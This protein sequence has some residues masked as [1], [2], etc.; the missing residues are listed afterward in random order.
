MTLLIIILFCVC[1]S[2]KRSA[3]LSQFVIHRGLIISVMQVGQWSQSNWPGRKRPISINVNRIV[4]SEVFA[5]IE[6]IYILF[7]SVDRIGGV[8]LCILF[9]L[10]VAFF[11]ISHD[12]VSIPYVAF[13]NTILLCMVTSPPLGWWIQSHKPSV[14][15]ER[16]IQC[17]KKKIVAF[18]FFDRIAFCNKTD[19]IRELDAAAFIDFF[20]FQYFYIFN[21][22]RNAWLQFV[23]YNSLRAMF[24]S[25]FLTLTNPKFRSIIAMAP[26]TRCFQFSLS[27]WTKMSLLTSH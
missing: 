14:D 2:Y 17:L 1:F 6:L 19:P 10:S 21:R 15:V 7:V 16:F 9:C 4:D 8:F 11:R 18:S 13:T 12:W 25:W 23:K 27:C 3:A 20:Y 22:R 26:C 5:Q 24:Q